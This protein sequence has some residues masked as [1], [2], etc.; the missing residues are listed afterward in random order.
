[1][2]QKIMIFGKPGG[3]KS[4]LAKKMSRMLNLPCVPLDAIEY[5]S[6]GSR[7]PAAEFANMHDQLIEQ[8]EWIIDGLGRMDAFWKRLA[9]ADTLIYIDLPYRGHYWRVTKRG[10]LGCIRHPEGWPEGT[11]VWQGTLRSYETLRRCPQFWNED[12][13]EKLSKHG[14]G[15]NFIRLTTV[16]SFNQFVAKLS[17]MKQ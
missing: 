10:L 8:N 17:T 5:A 3:G 14:S 4:T 1:M 9:A 7:V 15:K 11:S 12:F 6:D 16:R 2:M 13:H